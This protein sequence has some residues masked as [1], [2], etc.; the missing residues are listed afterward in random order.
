MFPR[1]SLLAD[2]AAELRNYPM[3]PLE[4]KLKSFSLRRPE[5][6]NHIVTPDEATEYIRWMAAEY[7]GS[8]S[9]DE[10]PF[11]MDG[12]NVSSVAD[13][14]LGESPSGRGKIIS[15]DLKKIYN[16]PSEAD[17]F[18]DSQSISVGRFLHYMPA[19]ANSSEVFELF[20]SFSGVPR[21][22]IGDESIELSPGSLILIPPGTIKAISCAMDDAVLVNV[23]LRAT[24][25]SE[26]FLQAL[27]DES[28]MSLFFRQAL[29]PGGG[30]DY[31]MFDTSRDTDMEFLLYAIY[32]QYK[33]R[34]TY[35]EKL[36]ESMMNTF[37]LLLLQRYEETAKLAK[38][39]GLSW[40]PGFTDML[41]YIQDNCESVTVENLADR[42]GYSKRQIIR[43]VQSCTGEGLSELTVRFKMEK[44]GKLVLSGV[45]TENAAARLGYASVP[46]FI[47]AFSSYYGCTPTKYRKMSL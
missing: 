31:I 7:T 30:T 42:Y 10:V 21:V 15:T 19:F 32:S 17:Y 29:E 38:R 45:S 34:S 47:R 35:S 11:I 23:M 5:M 22:Y 40:K 25:F 44:A 33:S 46:S 6:F 37:F 24:T 13:T 16:N 2:K 4:E 27:S 39:N 20:Y 18:T 36:A 26:V 8:A 9:R 12:G 1:F 3:L 43:I 41:R 14:L 28:I